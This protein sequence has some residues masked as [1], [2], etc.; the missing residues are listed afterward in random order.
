MQEMFTHGSFRY[1]RIEMSR[2]LPIQ[3]PQNRTSGPT[4]RLRRGGSKSAAGARPAPWRAAFALPR[5]TFHLALVALTIVTVSRVHQALG[6]LS[7]VRPALLL[8]IF[9]VGCVLLKPSLVRSDLLFRTWPPKVLVGLGVMACISV[10]FGISMGG[11]AMFILTEFSKVLVFGLFL[12]AAIRR[13]GDLRI[14]VWAY[15]ISCGILVGFA[16]F[17]FGLSTVA[18]SG[19]A[20]IQGLYTYDSND[21]GLVLMV[22]LPLTILT[23]QTALT[24]RARV[25]S[26]AII[27]G[28]GVAVALSGSRGAFLGLVCVGLALLFVLKQIPLV[29]RVG[30]VLA[31]GVALVIAAPPGYWEQMQTITNPT[32]DY[33]WDARYGRRQV[34]LR[35]LGYFAGN[36]ITG[37]GAG[38]YGRA[39]GTISAPAQNFENRVGERLKWSVAHNS[40]VEVL[41]EMGLPGFLLWSS[42]VFG[43]MISL[44]R[45][46][47]R[48]PYAW[49]RGDPEQRFLYEATIYVPIA[50]IGFASTAFFVSFTYQDP[51]YILAAFVAGIHVAVRDRVLRERR[52]GGAGAQPEMAE[53]QQASRSGRRINRPVPSHLRRA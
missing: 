46:R 50:L 51:I 10:P 13:S 4:G 17:G 53:A 40:F 31:V 30:F 18:G 29:K 9:A 25:V 27:A 7:A 16:M 22:G 8:F 24:R 47:R 19:V 28:T 5:D 52:F 39:E 44:V 6:P 42:L 11:S 41:A 37:I 49:A 48:L 34:W 36:P 12:M 2:G 35:G 38:N 23:M 14:F 1:R 32:A 21:L 15:V 43:G 33:N 3:R 45:L 26:G 20:R